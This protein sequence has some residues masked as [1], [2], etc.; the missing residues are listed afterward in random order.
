MN[1][2]DIAILTT[3]DELLSG[4]LTDT[5]TGT[6]AEIL[7]HHGYRLRCSLSV[8]D[9]EKEI[10]AALTYLVGHV[11]FVIV[12]GGLGSTGDDLTARAA[13]RA[14]NQ[15]LVINEDALDMVRQ[16]FSMR[17]GRWNQAMNARRCCLRWPNPYLTTS[18]RHQVSGL[19][20]VVAN[21]FFYPACQ[22]K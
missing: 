7:S 11:R 19:N 6:V 18:V 2:Y 8:A 10:S 15:P 17:N 14:L 12:T 21:C 3:G 5:N 4:E 9:Q 16:W 20:T 13:S 22:Q 1:A